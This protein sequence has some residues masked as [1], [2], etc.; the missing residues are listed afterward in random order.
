MEASVGY[1]LNHVQQA[2]VQRDA[3]AK[4]VLPSVVQR[5]APPA[6]DASGKED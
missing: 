6:A 5:S 1:W 4:A 3:S 2:N